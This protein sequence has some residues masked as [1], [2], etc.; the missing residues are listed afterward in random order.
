M[1]AQPDR[2]F[3]VRDASIA[4]ALGLGCALGAAWLHQGWLLG[5][6]AALLEKLRPLRGPHELGSHALYLPLGRLLGSVAQL[7]AY[8]A[9][10]ALGW[11]SAGVI[12]ASV[13]SS[14][15]LLGV[16]ARAG[17]AAALL[18]VAS[19]GIAFHTTVIEVHALHAAHVA[20]GL[21]LIL[22]VDSRRP[23]AVLATASLVAG[24]LILTHRSGV[25]CAAPLTL[26]A[27]GRAGAAK[28]RAAGLRSLILSA[29]AVGGGALLG[30]ALDQALHVIFGGPDWFQAREL[31]AREQTGP[32]LALVLKEAV[33][34]FGVLLPLGLVGSL[35][36]R[37]STVT[38][39]WL[40]VGILVH[41]A[42]VVLFGVPTRGGYVSPAIVF[43]AIA[44]ARALDGLRGRVVV[45]VLLLLAAQGWLGLRAIDTVEARTKRRAAEQRLELARALLPDGGLMVTA[46]LGYQLVTGR[47][48]G[49]R[50][51]NLGHELGR[52]IA[53]GTSPS[54][55]DAAA[56]AP[57]IDLIRDSDKR[58]VW[59]RDWAA[60]PAIRTAVAPYMVPIEEALRRE[61]GG[62][63][64]NADGVDAVVLRP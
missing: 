22:A 18:A 41:P 9:L 60:D 11:L 44:A 14:A 13:F 10:A 49:I 48:P 39:A 43:A 38:S 37:R 35:W 42:A 17:S 8:H 58:V 5:D 21:T 32:S 46:D 57:L 25:L 63:D 54:D 59:V 15:R 51:F 47:L 16:G 1:T 28:P 6:A 52:A 31:L 24:T 4:V 7:E 34:P 3:T 61:F 2:P 40:L 30:V 29:T 26:L 62:R 27:W 50:E 56:T 64:V 23:R 33:L 20:A 55:F 53:A 36:P 19:P 45:L 12:A